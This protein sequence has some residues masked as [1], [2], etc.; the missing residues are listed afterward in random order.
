VL[1]FFWLADLG[2]GIVLHFYIQAFAG[3]ADWRD[4]A[5]GLNSTARANLGGKLSLGQPFLYDSLQ[6]S[7]PAIGLLLA[8]LLTVAIVRAS[9][10]KSP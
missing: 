2:L 8:G 9:R 3:Q 6:A 7:L 5:H 4:F 1:F 10:K